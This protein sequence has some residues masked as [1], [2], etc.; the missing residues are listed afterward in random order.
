MKGSDIK[1]STCEN[2]FERIIDTSPMYSYYPT[3]IHYKS[4]NR[5]CGRPNVA[6]P[7][8]GAGDK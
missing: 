7:L 2:C 1:E 5:E 3:W 8:K 4:Q 6:L